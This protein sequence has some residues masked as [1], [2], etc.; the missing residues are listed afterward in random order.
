MQGFLE[1]DA[2]PKIREYQA[3]AKEYI[4]IDVSTLLESMGKRAPEGKA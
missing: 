4:D 1:Q 2:G 3:L